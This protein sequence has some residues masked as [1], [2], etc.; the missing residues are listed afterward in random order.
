MHRLTAIVFCL[1]IVS[2][3]YAETSPQ[4]SQASRLNHAVLRSQAAGKIVSLLSGPESGLPRELVDRAEAFAVFPRVITEAIL[5]SETCKGYGVISSRSDSG[6]TLPAFYRFTGDK[7]SSTFF[8][9]QETS[10]IVLLF[11]NKD[12]VASFVKGG[13]SLQ[14]KTRA[15][16]GPVGKITQRQLEAYAGTSV[17][18]YAYYNGTLRGAE[19]KGS[20]FNT[21]L[22]TPDNNINK[23]LY[24]VKGREVVLGKKIDESTVLNAISAYLDAL[25]K[26]YP[27]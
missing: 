23:P 24:G 1:L 27:R 25:A 5:F 7:Y 26:S 14:G 22:I 13:V 8:D 21:F 6:W 3:G 15:V 17:L 20:F 19:Y 9:E 16:A 4:E 2:G 18:A 12:V 10:A 11:M